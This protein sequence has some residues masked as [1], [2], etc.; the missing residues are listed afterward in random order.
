[1]KKLIIGLLILISIV[2]SVWG[3]SN[4][5][6]L[7]LQ[8]V[9]EMN[10]S[11]LEEAISDGANLNYM[12]TNDKTVLMYATENQW[13]PGVKMLLENGANASFKNTAGQTSLM[14]AAKYCNNDTIVILLRKFGANIE[15]S[16]NSRKT[17][18][19]YAAE[20]Q[21]DAIVDYLIRE[22]VNLGA[23][24]RYGNNAAMWAA[25]VGNIFTMEK[26]MQASAVNWEQADM[27]GNDVFTLA[28]L[29]GNTNLVKRLL[30]G[31]TDFDIEGA[32]A[33]GDP[34]LIR[35]I[36]KKASNTV[37]ELVINQHDPERIFDLKD[38]NNHNV[39]YWAKRMKN[40][41]VTKKLDEIE[42]EWR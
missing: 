13:Y 14:F 26:F 3:A 41:Y 7:L 28:C 10:L 11:L 24:D 18:L 25:K 9:R 1:M 42:K 5:D 21:S 38:I 16:D 40:T 15:N 32:N 6:K 27:D 20:N 31:N 33:T 12:D 34:L 19:M 29:S 37:I 35:L 2:G 22:G 17:V 30:L 39:R 36:K 4:A 23:I 8:A